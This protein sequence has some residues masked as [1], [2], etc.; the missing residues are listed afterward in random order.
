MPT[1]LD[2]LIAT[3]NRGKI[4]EIEQALRLLPLKLHYLD[5]FPNLGAVAEVGQT[6]EANAVL[7]AMEYSRQSGMCALADDS[8]LEVDS[9]DG[10]PGVFSARYAGEGA[11]DND[12]IQKLLAA[13]SSCTDEERRARFVCCMV[14]VGWQA[15]AAKTT[16]PE[17]IQVTWGKCEGWIVRAPRGENGFGF[18]PVF[19]PSG[20]AE[21]FGELSGAVK[22]TMSHRALA[23]NEM[24][25]FLTRWLGQT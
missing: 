10:A 4:R 3:H 5:E 14:L 13:L 9:L 25:M 21:T 7:K 16:A 19:I 11:S 18:D 2:L 17:M 15:G 12:R 6:Y 20:Y 8:G 1:Q 23:L 22:A 24:R